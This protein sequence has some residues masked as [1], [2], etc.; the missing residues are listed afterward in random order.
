M[1]VIRRRDEDYPQ[2]T[3]RPRFLQPVRFNSEGE[4]ISKGD[5][6]EVYWVYEG[7]DDDGDE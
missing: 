1:K 6:E 5:W 4:V 7:D 2:G 3:P